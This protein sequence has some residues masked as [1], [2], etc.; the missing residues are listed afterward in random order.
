MDQ[1]ERQPKEKPKGR[2]KLA[3]PKAKPLP[4]QK[5]CMPA[6]VHVKASGRGPA[7]LPGKGVETNQ[8]IYTYG[9]SPKNSLR[10]NTHAE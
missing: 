6:T 2:V 9:P 7:Y 10:T 3:T 8:T 4:N 5:P 1:P